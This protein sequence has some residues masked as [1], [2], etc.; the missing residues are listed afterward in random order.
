MSRAYFAVG[1]ANREEVDRLPCIARCRLGCGGQGKAL[2]TD[3]LD[4]IE[5]LGRVSQR[6]AS[7]GWSRAARTAQRKTIVRLHLAYRALSS[8][9]RLDLRE[10]GEWLRYLWRLRG[11]SK[12]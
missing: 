11:T 2:R 4:R 9:L 6:A 5:A 7:L 1:G 8:A 12:R 10:S 3:Q